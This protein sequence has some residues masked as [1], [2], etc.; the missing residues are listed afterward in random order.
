MSRARAVL[1][2]LAAV[3]LAASGMVAEE[4]T[5]RARLVPLPVELPDAEIAVAYQRAAEQNVLAAVNPKVFA[6][7][8]S[9]CADGQGFGCGNTYPSLDGHQMTDALLFL[10]QV[11]TVQANWDYVLSFQRPNGQL[12]LAILPAAAGGKLPY[13][14]PVDANGGLYKHWV[15]GDPLRALAGPTYIQNADVIFRRTGDRAWLAAQLASINL[16]ADYLAGLTREDGAVGG[17]GYYIERPTRIEYDGV[18]QCH[19]ADAF[20]RVAELNRV[21][22]HDDAARRYQGLADRV[23]AHFRKAFWVEDKGHFAE[24]IHPTRGLTLLRHREIV[25]LCRE[26]S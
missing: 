13:D 8:W 9:V 17:A 12:P 10:G 15:P 20:R 3:P 11:E 22:G 19:A 2:A 26:G 5:Q 21:L 18:T 24:Y 23:R 14:T 7:Y 6:G 25:C 1:F 16:A 4:Q